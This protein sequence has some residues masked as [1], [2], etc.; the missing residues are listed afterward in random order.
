MSVLQP[1][2]RA[3]SDSSACCTPQAVIRVPA[4]LVAAA[5]KPGLLCFFSTVNVS[6]LFFNVKMFSH[7]RQG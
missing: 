7:E 6:Q 4:G 3:P 5:A 1:Q 2:E